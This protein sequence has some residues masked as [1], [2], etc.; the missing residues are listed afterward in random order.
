MTVLFA[1]IRNFTTISE[2][3]EPKELTQ[4]MNEFFTPMTRI[5][6]QHRG[7]IDKYIGDMVMAFWGAPLDDPD[8]ARHAVEAGMEMLE[9]LKQI[10][11]VFKLRG[12][13]EIRIGIG[14][15]T[16][17]M[18]VGNMGS[19]FRVAY[20]VMGDAVNLGSRL[21]GLTKEYGVSCVVSEFTRARA[22]DFLYRELDRVRVKGKAEPITIYQ[23]V[24]PLADQAPE[25]LG[26]IEL[27]HQALAHYQAQAWDQA[28]TCLHS[29]QQ[30]S[31]CQLY[32][33]Y[34]DRIQS[35]RQQPPPADWD[36]VF[37]FTTK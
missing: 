25:I 6:H 35:F 14:I 5:I 11:L 1:D 24:G 10:R 13:P 23:P 31:P 4:M 36:G 15:N 27:F 8:H 18:N 12:W 37:S 34:L 28:E 20:T 33:L 9:R 32:Q 26:E 3:V 17:V 19:E 7:T 30:Q 22:G 16:G 2:G 21:E 29:L